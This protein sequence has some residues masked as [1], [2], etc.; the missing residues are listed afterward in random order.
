MA[1]VR[2]EQNGFSNAL[3]V[4][5]SAT[6]GVAC[7]GKVAVAIHREVE[8]GIIAH[9]AA[10]GGEFTVHY[11][12]RERV[13]LAIGRRIKSNVEYLPENITNDDIENFLQHSSC[14]ERCADIICGAC[15]CTCKVS[16]L[17]R[18]ET[19]LS[20]PL[21]KARNLGMKFFFL[22]TGWSSPF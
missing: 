4:Q 19:I 7:D 11:T 12:R 2:P 20:P 5:S 8:E 1:V 21:H 22:L 17:V 16:K 9:Q 15:V 18:P 14:C 13:Y 3:A 10:P 6:T